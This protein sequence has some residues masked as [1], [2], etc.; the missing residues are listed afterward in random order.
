MPELCFG[1]SFRVN[2]I[3]NK[4]KCLKNKLQYKRGLIPEIYRID[5]LTIK[6]GK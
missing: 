2:I 5:V 6:L 1:Y 4:P 3:Q